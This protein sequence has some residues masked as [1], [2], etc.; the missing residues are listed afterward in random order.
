LQ[1]RFTDTWLN[2]FRWTSPL[3]GT[4]FAVQRHPFDA[5][6]KKFDL[7][8]GYYQ[9]EKVVSTDLALRVQSVI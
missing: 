7:E 4:P 8:V 9:S 1:S 6:K 2:A 5:K 3:L